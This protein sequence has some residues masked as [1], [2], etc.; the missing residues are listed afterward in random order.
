[1]VWQ[2]SENA[3]KEGRWIGSRVLNGPR[4]GIGGVGEE[5][6]WGVTSSELCCLRVSSPTDTGVGIFTPSSHFE[7]SVMFMA[8][9][10]S[11]QI[12][13]PP[14]RP[15]PLK[16]AHPLSFS[17][18]RFIIDCNAV[19]AGSIPGWGR[20]PGKGNGNPLQYSCLKNSMDRGAW[21][22]TVHGVAKSWTRL[23]DQHTR[24]MFFF[25]I[26]LYYSIK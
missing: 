4:W 18:F 25:K 24:T 14:R 11:G 3:H 19:V 26:S 23:Q 12:F 7:T 17:F 9:H 1:M 20:S 22:A 6:A 16:V 8:A 2:S 5:S 21:W 15:P 13:P 10:V